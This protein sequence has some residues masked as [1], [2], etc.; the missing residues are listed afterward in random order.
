MSKNEKTLA[1]SKRLLD[2]ISA[3]ARPERVAEERVIEER[4]KSEA[5]ERQVQALPQA[6][7]A[8]SNPLMQEAVTAGD[9]EDALASTAKRDEA[10]AK[11]ATTDWSVTSNPF[12]FFA[13]STTPSTEKKPAE[14]A[15]SVEK[16]APKETADLKTTL[17]QAS[18]LDIPHQE[19]ATIANPFAEV[20]E[21][22][23]EAVGEAPLESLMSSPTQTT[24]N[25]FTQTPMEA[26]LETPPS[27]EAAAV[28]ST[29]SLIS[30]AT[31]I[32]PQ[33]KETFPTKADI[34]APFHASKDV[35]RLPSAVPAAEEP[36]GGEAAGVTE[37]DAERGTMH[38]NGQTA[39]RSSVSRFGV[40]WRSFKKGIVHYLSADYQSTK[41]RLSVVFG[42]GGM[43][44][45]RSSYSASPEITDLRFFPL[46]QIDSGDR[47][48]II[49]E[50]GRI[51]G[52]Y[53][54]EARNAKGL[55]LNMFLPIGTRSQ[56]FIIDL[57]DNIEGDALDSVALLT[58]LEQKHFDA[59]EFY[60]DY[61]T[62]AQIATGKKGERRTRYY[63]LAAPVETVDAFIEETRKAG[64]PVTGL[65]SRN[66][67]ATSLVQRD[68]LPRPAWKNYITIFVGEEST[69]VALMVGGLP[70]TRR[71]LR[72]GTADMFELM[73]EKGITDSPLEAVRHP[74]AAVDRTVRRK[75]CRQ[76][77]TEEEFHHLGF[78]LEEAI[79]RIASFTHRI[80]YF[81]IFSDSSASFEGVYIVAPDTVGE[82]LKARFEKDDGLPVVRSSLLAGSF[83][84]RAR[85]AA[86]SLYEEGFAGLAA[87]AVGLSLAA[88]AVPNLIDRAPIRRR[89]H[90]EQRLT[91]SLALFL[92]AVGFAGLLVTAGNMW[93]YGEL[94]EESARLEA[95][96]PDLARR[97]SVSDIRAGL[98]RLEGISTRANE[99][100][101][102]RGIVLALVDLDQFVRDGVYFTG[103]SLQGA[104]AER[105]NTRNNNAQ[106]STDER[107]LRISGVVLGTRMQRQ[108]LLT[109]LMRDLRRNPVLGD[110]TGFEGA[111]EAE[112]SQAFTLT[113]TRR[114]R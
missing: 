24:I 21:K 3:T 84:P 83:S 38:L 72:Y 92:A 5:T 27:N 4:S 15:P 52:K 11:R 35:K 46:T 19:R 86:M 28:A 104:A 73:E 81:H 31:E 78:V 26:P 74:L 6:H 65:T 112:R 50:A 100:A 29:E 108:L 114:A 82:I 95:S 99:V 61:R 53:F 41:D 43:M 39:E 89:R 30:A 37:V 7:R 79:D 22:P 96:M 55:R 80:S 51:L 110:L 69:I 44:L 33:V 13:V 49:E 32:A 109:E 14:E 9:A 103:V 102:R 25:P 57:P 76:N 48:A 1:A 105:G 23:K 64:I 34:A 107:V 20:Q 12:D 113:F 47:Q 36:R 101:R 67:S 45:A 17:A 87:D 56:D 60:F 88:K 77:L 106:T 75:L 94:T 42:L 54:A 62:I 93:R 91:A 8:F 70:V 58:A 111:Q 68:W 18:V 66:F 63:G 16:E 2:Y 59:Q 97:L 98:M 85:V 71:R 40:K 10:P 90:H